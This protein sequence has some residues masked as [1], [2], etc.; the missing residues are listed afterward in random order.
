[1]QFEVSQCEFS[2]RGCSFIQKDQ[3]YNIVKDILL[4]LKLLLNEKCQ[5]FVCVIKV[6]CIALHPKSSLHRSD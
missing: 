2:K 4:V 6:E 5:C 1:M 3:L